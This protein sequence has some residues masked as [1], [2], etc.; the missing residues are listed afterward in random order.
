M[1]SARFKL[2]CLSLVA[3]AA[4]MVHGHAASALSDHLQINTLAGVPVI[5]FDLTEGE[6]ESIGLSA[7]GISPGAP[8]PGFNAQFSV[9]LTEPPGEPVTPGET[10]YYLPTGEAI[11]D[12][13]MVDGVSQGIFFASDGDPNFGSYVTIALGLPFFALVETGELQDLTPYLPGSPNQILVQSDVVP[14]PATA[15]LLV[16]GLV[17]MALRRRAVL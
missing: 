11:S 17:G 6:L 16:A 1:S 10:V 9:I 2:F 15:A 7:L 3:F 8:P 12:L 14:E 13:L 4:F 5:G